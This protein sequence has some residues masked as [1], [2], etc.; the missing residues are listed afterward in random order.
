MLI[1]SKV[2]HKQSSEMTLDL[3]RKKKKE[4]LFT[5]IDL[6]AGIGG[7]H[8]A[9]HNLGGECVYASEW[10]L[11]ARSTYR[12]NFYNI[13]PDLFDNDMFR[14]DITL[15]ENQDCIPNDVDILCGG[16][17]CQPFSQAGYKKGFEETRGTL[18]FEIAKIIKNKQPKTFFLENVRHLF[19]HNDGK[20]FETIK[21]IIENDLEYSFAFQIIKASDYGLPTYRPRL[22]MIGFRNDLKNNIDFRF[23][24][25]IPLKFTMS[26]VFEGRCNK[27]IGY[28]IRVGGRGSGIGDRRN[29]DSYLVN[30]K[31]QRI[32]PREVKIMMGFPQDFI[33]P[34]TETQALKQLGNSVAVLPVQ[35]V[36]AKILEAIGIKN[37]AQN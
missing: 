27:E 36:T 26:H 18:F 32:S 19:S 5:F 12:E 6:F 25:P 20:T 35:M 30:E 1:L 31:E 33:F 9:L 14:G 3:S 34:V 29:W 7:F 16:F 24:D 28:T 21:K 15:K 10:N 13:C 8:I 11:H 2:T 22:F 4:S 17:P 23:P 37:D